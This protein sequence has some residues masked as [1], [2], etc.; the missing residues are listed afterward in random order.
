MGAL[1]YTLIDDGKD[2]FN[3]SDV[4]AFMKDIGGVGSGG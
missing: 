2:N 1:E 4:K 3:M